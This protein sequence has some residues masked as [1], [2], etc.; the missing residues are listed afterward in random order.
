[1]IKTGM[2]ILAAAVLSFAVAAE[3][4]LA[5][6]IKDAW[7]RALPP[8]QPNTAAYLTLVN[9][10]EVAVT[11][12]NAT[13]DVADTVEIHT[14]RDIDGL[15][16]MEQLHEL[17][18]APGE[19]VALAPGGTHLMLLGLESMPVTGDKVQLCLQ[20]DSGD[21]VCTLASVRKSGER[22]DSATH[23]HHH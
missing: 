7:V 21:E 1:M 9:K 23:Q 19:Q 8:L 2:A 4:D 3:Q 13:S 15:M 10:G 6:E 12:V 17:Q 22:S 20:T 11:I 18:L 5:L 16:R 14:T